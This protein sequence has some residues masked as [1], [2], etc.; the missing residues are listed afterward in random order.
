LAFKAFAIAWIFSTNHLLLQED[1]NII[2]GE[3]LEIRQRQEVEFAKGVYQRG[4]S[5][6]QKKH[7][8][9]STYS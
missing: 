5:C 7:L 2:I 1:Y 3:Y 4:A 8:L 9:R 6:P